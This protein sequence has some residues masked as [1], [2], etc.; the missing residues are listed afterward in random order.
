MT[1][2]EKEDQDKSQAE[3]SFMIGHRRFPDVRGISLDLFRPRIKLLLIQSQLAVCAL[4]G[5]T[6]IPF[7]EGAIVLHAA[8][9]GQESNVADPNHRHSKSHLV[10][11]LHLR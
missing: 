3:E 5:E 9:T 10:F 6:L 8:H 1:S 4:S 7:N 11:P 2:Q